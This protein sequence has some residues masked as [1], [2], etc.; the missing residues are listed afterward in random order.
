M[1]R[2]IRLS[3]ILFLFNPL[4]IKKDSLMSVSHL[5]LK[6]LRVADRLLTEVIAK[7]ERRELRSRRSSLCHSHNF[8]R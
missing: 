4:S 3:A 1:V 6:N 5:L 8:G 2:A 7:K